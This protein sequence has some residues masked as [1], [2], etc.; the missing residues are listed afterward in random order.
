MSLLLREKV[1]IAL[2]PER[3]EVMRLARGLKSGVV[4][5]HTL[6]CDESAPDEAPWAKVLDS[7]EAGLRALVEKPMDAMVV[8]SNHF[9]RYALVPWSDQVI[10]NDDEQAFIRHSFLQTYGDDARHWA[11]RIS[12]GGYGETRVASAI[13]QGLLDGLERIARERGLRLVSLQ[14]YLMTEFNRWRK[15]MQSSAVWFAVAEPG[16]LCLSLLR[17]GRWCKLQTVKAGDGWPDTLRKLLE[18]ELFVAA[19]SSESESG[20]ERGTVYLLAPGHA[21]DTVLPGWTVH[22]LGA[23]PGAVPDGEIQFAMNMDG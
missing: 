15:Q 14:P 6:P 2:S 23:Q 5:R 10:N 12:P 18:R 11:L 9:V 8:L 3:V 16:R 13:D 22:R 20:Q 21:A 17:Q 1:R 19:S 7:L 4:A